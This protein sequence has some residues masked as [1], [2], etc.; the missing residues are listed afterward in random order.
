MAGTRK[1]PFDKIGNLF[2]KHLWPWFLVTIWPVLRRRIEEFVLALLDRIFQRWNEAQRERQERRRRE[3]QDK[4]AAAE[5]AAATAK[6]KEDESYHR[7]EAEIWKRIAE[8]Y[9]KD[10]EEMRRE[11]KRMSDEAKR[12]LKRGLKELDPKGQIKRGEGNTV[13]IEGEASPLA[14]P[15]FD[16]DAAN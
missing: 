10:L 8:E 9:R 4:A 5:Q 15:N 13:M 1:V 2:F 6:S 11:S 7:R 16:D 14:L 3:A 12:D